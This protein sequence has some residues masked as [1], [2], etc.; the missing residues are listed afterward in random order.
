MLVYFVSDRWCKNQGIEYQC[1]AIDA[2]HHNLKTQDCRW[3]RWL[4]SLSFYHTSWKCTGDVT[5]LTRFYK[6]FPT[7]ADM[8]ISLLSLSLLP[9]SVFRKSRR[10]PVNE[11]EVAL[12]LKKK[13]M[14]FWFNLNV[15]LWH[16]IVNET[17]LI[18][19]FS[20]LLSGKAA[21]TAVTLVAGN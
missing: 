3:N 7:C 4:I 12:Y 20:V 9:S 6:N 21:V 8:S 13:E 18:W 17:K 19:C 2:N 1:H 11:K 16:L 5:K 14:E 15:T 10:H